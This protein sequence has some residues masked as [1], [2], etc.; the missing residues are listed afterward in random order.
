MITYCGRPPIGQSGSCMRTGHGR[1][2]GDFAR[3][4]AFQS[5]TMLA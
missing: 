4:A 1:A 3:I 2:H 5:L